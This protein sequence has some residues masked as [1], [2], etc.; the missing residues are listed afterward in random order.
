[1]NFRNVS[2]LRNPLILVVVTIGSFTLYELAMHAK[3]THSISVEDVTKQLAVDTPVGTSR[4]SVENYLYSRSIPHTFVDNP[5]FPDERRVEIALIR[6]AAESWLTKGSIQIRFRFDES[7]KL[8][9][10]SVHEVF[11]GP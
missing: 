7:D 11:T 2:P 4:A 3:V 6:D 9:G 10:Y 1:M 5:K 8:L